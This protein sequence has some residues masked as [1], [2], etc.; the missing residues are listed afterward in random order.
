MR[1]SVLNPVSF[2]VILLFVAQMIGLRVDAQ[3]STLPTLNNPICTDVTQQ[4]APRIVNDGSGGAIIAWWDYD[5]SENDYDIYAQRISSEGIL[6]WSPRGVEICTNSKSQSV[7][8][9]ISDGKGGA[10]IAWFDSRTGKNLVYIQ[11][12]NSSGEVSWQENGVPVAANSDNIDQ[13]MPVI[14]SDNRGGAIICWKDMRYSGFSEKSGIY[15]QRIDSTSTR[16]WGDGGICVR[17]YGGEVPQIVSDG[18]GGA[19]IAWTNYI[20]TYPNGH[21]DIYVQKIDLNGSIAWQSDGIALCSRIHDQRDVQITGD[22]SGG[23]IVVWEDYRNGTYSNL[24]AQKI[25]AA[26]VIQWEAD[27]IAVAPLDYGQ[28]FHRIISD[29]SGGV[30]AAWQYSFNKVYAQRISS[31]GIRQWASDGISVCSSY[32]S[33][34]PQITNDGQNGIILTWDDK[35]GTGTG[36]I[37]AQRINQ[38]GNL[39]WGDAGKC[40]SGLSSPQYGPAITYEGRGGAILVWEDQR[41][42]SAS[43]IDIYAQ[44]VGADGTL[45]VVTTGLNDYLRSDSDNMMLKQ[46]YPNPFA[47]ETEIGFTL[48]AAGHVELKVFNV[49]G[50]EVRSLIDSNLDQGDY[51]IR[52][53]AQG[54]PGGVYFYR[55]ETDGRSELKT[56]LIVL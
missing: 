10:I 1:H 16:I 21:K 26:G 55:L 32:D 17:E 37:Y 54:L 40:I 44:M 43:S 3:W 14:A 28:R 49:Y 51:T 11:K 45:G 6:Q 50:K 48:P 31:D 4:Q 5:V 13:S 24:Y 38:T 25:N 7:P 27:G 52:F 42:M 36:D 9:I 46:N 18:Q 33:R 39:L 12:I 53:N 29:G 15:A 20:G 34:A 56:M 41:D 22:C 47:H 30:Y 23:A 2:G 35:R 19:L 8:V